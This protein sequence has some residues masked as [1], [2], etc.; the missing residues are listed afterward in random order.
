MKDIMKTFKN[1]DESG[2]S[3]KV[4]SETFAINAKIQ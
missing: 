4:A 1:V 2:L 3:I